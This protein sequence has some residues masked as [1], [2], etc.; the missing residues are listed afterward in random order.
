[1]KTR[2]LWYELTGFF[3]PGTLNS[4]PLNLCYANLA[5]GLPYTS[6]KISIMRDKKQTVERYQGK[7]KN[8]QGGV[9]DFNQHKK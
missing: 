7:N 1:M 6:G 4:E 5:D 2:S 3:Q 8:K 9:H